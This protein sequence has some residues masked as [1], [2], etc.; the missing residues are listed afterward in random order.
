MIRFSSAIC[1]LLLS[2]VLLGCG[3]GVQLPTGRRVRDDGEDESP[4]QTVAQA[5]AAKASPPEEKATVEPPAKSAPDKEV[6]ATPEGKGTTNA[7]PANPPAKATANSATSP[8]G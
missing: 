8:P 1:C 4:A 2:V 3:G 6:A 7:A 5:P